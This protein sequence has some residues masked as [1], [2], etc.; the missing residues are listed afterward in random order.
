[1]RAKEMKSAMHNIMVDNEIDMCDVPARTALLT[2]IDKIT[3]KGTDSIQGIDFEERYVNVPA[4]HLKKIYN[5]LRKEFELVTMQELTEKEVKK[6]SKEIVWGSLYL[7][8]YSNSLG[9]KPNIVAEFAES[10]LE[11]KRNPEECGEYD[12]FYDYIQSVEY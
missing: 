9:V 4:K 7:S 12:S 3:L 8:D 10:Y 6:L 5:F 2:G 11:A 1:M